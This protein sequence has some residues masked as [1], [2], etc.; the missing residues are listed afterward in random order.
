MLPC[1]GGEKILRALFEPLGY[2]VRVEG[3]PLDESFPEWGLSRYY[4]LRLEGQVRLRDL[5]SHLYVL[6]PVLDSAKHYWIGEDEIEKL[7]RHGEGW[8]AA[9][10]L[11][12]YVAARYLKRS[13]HL[14]K[15]ALLRLAEAEDSVA[16][17][18]DDEEEDEDADA[19]N[20]EQPAELER[21]CGLNRQRLGAV[22]A[23]LKNSGAG[24]VLDLGCGSG[25]LLSLLRREKQ[26]TQIAGM[27]VSGIA[28]ERA[29]QKLHL[30]RVTNAEKERF[31]LIQS[32]FLYRDKRLAGYDACAAVEVV[33]HIDPSRL[34][35][36]EKNLFE[37]I[38]CKTIALTTPNREYNDNYA[39]QQGGLRHED[40]RFEWTRAEFQAWAVRLAGQYGYSVRFAGIGEADPARGTPTQL[41]VFER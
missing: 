27:D 35:F 3:F 14:V 21:R 40:H 18:D 13:R 1:R 11:K 9:H 22:V 2:A 31:R 8:L 7:L 16:A 36:F 19:E 39:F 34:G 24:R 37:H 17:G 30:D 6:I 41:A 26:F 25:L 29:A 5:L 20:A 10:P 15:A 32:S 23:V 28:L 38:H 12:E 33:E 4:N